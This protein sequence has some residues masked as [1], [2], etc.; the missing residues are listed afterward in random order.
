MLQ[1]CPNSRDIGNLVR[2]DKG[3]APSLSFGFAVALEVNKQAHTRQGIALGRQIDVIGNGDQINH[4]KTCGH[5][6][7]MWAAP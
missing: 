2:A 1:N 6:R 5:Y 4:G 7:A 3:V